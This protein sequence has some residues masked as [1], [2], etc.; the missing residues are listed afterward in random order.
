M[1]SRR[2][3]ILNFIGLTLALVYSIGG[4][5]S[6]PNIG[7]FREQ[8]EADLLKNIEQA[9]TGKEASRVARPFLGIMVNISHNANIALLVS[10]GVICLNGIIFLINLV[11][12]RPK[13]PLGVDSKKE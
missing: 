3:R 11:G 8:D 10:W 13:K 7:S 2:I 12:D 6:G 4:L 5:I 9:P 1:I